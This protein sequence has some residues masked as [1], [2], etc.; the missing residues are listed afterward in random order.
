MKRKV[1]KMNNVDGKTKVFGLIGNPVEHTLSPFIHNTLANKLGIN[2]I[3]VPFHV[4]KDYIKHA[5][6]G[7]KS[8]NIKG[9]NVT[10]PYKVEMFN[11]LQS[12]D[13]KA[14]KIGAVNVVNIDSNK[15]LHGFNTDADG[16]LKSCVRAGINIQDKP[17]C[18]IGAGGAARA[19]SI[20]CAEENVSSIV[21]VNRT[22]S[23][24]QELKQLIN[25]YYNIEVTVLSYDEIDKI[26]NIYTCFQTTSVGMHPNINSSTI[27]DANFFRDCEWAVDLVYNPSKTKFLKLAED[28]G[29]KILNGL[30]MLYYQ[31]VAAF[32]IWND[33]KVNDKIL[34]ECIKIL[35]NFVYN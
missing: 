10:V 16:L 19:V 8:L 26:S 20:M 15:N 18:I 14:M 35:E 21:I 32:E 27:E 28:K 2:M 22:V 7:L 9:V 11:L 23:K 25:K 1:S 33:I 4:E 12:I 31:A 5:F 30:G 24:A 6:N 13:E 34:D 3:Y 29:T 17:A